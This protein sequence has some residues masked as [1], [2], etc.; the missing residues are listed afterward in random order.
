MKVLVLSLVSLVFFVI[1]YSGDLKFYF[2]GENRVLCWQR[3]NL[4]F[5]LSFFGPAFLLSTLISFRVSDQVF[6]AWKKITFYFIPIYAFII[7]LMPWSVGDE[8]AGFTKGMV[9]L[10]LTGGYMIFSCIYLL[11]KKH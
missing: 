3:F 5:I 11:T 6:N 7:I 4:I 8:I 10:V 9:G 1:L 2:C